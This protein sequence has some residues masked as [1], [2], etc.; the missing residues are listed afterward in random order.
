MMFCVINPSSNTSLINKV[1]VGMVIIIPLRFIKQKLGS[2]RIRNA[3]LQAINQFY[4]FETL[5]SKFNL[6]EIVNM[7]TK[8]CYLISTIKSK[9]I[10]IKPAY[11]VKEH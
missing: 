9:G 11:P 7:P 6:R 5:F 2:F 8:P 3:N 4:I 10:M 1:L